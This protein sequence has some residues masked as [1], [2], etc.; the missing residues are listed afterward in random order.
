MRPAVSAQT[1]GLNTRQVPPL[2]AMVGQAGASMALP[3]SRPAAA[4][5]Q[6]EVPERMAKTMRILVL[7]VAASAFA[8]CDQSTSDSSNTAA[9]A[10][11]QA[12]TSNDKA[13]ASKVWTAYITRRAKSDAASVGYKV[14]KIQPSV[15]DPQDYGRGFKQGSGTAYVEVVTPERTKHGTIYSGD[16]SQNADG[17]WA[18]RPASVKQQAPETVGQ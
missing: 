1:V 6:R 8:G 2:A 14:V 15:D 7:L 9:T 10:T 17:T 5:P 18:V 16:M 13:R 3:V 11:T 4:R 12:T